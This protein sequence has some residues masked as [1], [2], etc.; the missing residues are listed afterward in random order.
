MKRYLVLLMVCFATIA[1]AQI[2]ADP[3]HWAFGIKKT[4]GNT[5]E[6]HLRCSIDD[7]WHIYAQK[8]TAD[9]IGT[10]TKVL[11]TKQKG[12]TL[13]GKPL[14]VGK[15]ETYIDKQA[16]ITNY[17]YSGMVDFVQKAIIAKGINVITGSITY[18]TCTHKKCLPE[19]NVTFSIPIN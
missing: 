9:F 15:K 4:T 3:A 7:G 1:K 14:E 17:E 16:E 18:Q 11:F 10:E 8:Q 12:V 13:I 19:T 6:I 5:Y 2:Q